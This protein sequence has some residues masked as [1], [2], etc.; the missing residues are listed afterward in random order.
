MKQNMTPETLRAKMQS[1]PAW[2]RAPLGIIIGI[3][4]VIT[5]PVWIP[6]AIGLMLF[7]EFFLDDNAPRM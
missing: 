5:A 4:I 3:V 1:Q 7:D 2:V 6:T